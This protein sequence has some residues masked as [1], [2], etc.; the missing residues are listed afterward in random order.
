M[1]QGRVH[2][3]RG[4]PHA[5]VGSDRVALVAQFSAGPVQPRSLSEYL[6]RLDAAGYATVVISTCETTAPLEFPAGVPTDTMVIRRP[7][8][9][10]D[11]GSWATALGCIP[12]LREA[13]TVLLTN[14]SLLGPFGPIEHLLEWAAAPGPDIRGLTA[15]YQFAYHV[16]S[17]FLAYR[18]GILADRPWRD[19]FNSVRVEPGKDEVVLSYEIGVSRTAFS[20]C[21]SSEV[22]VTGPELGVPYGNPTVDGW[23]NLI[24]SGVPFLKRTIMTHPSTQAEAAEAAQYIRRRFGTD[25]NDW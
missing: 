7:N 4:D 12:E 24:E 25:V 6:Q 9:G 17:Y 14:D 23:K 3:E 8:L 21:Y 18:G 22:W 19:F 11:F 10:Y 15:S 1:S 2:I 13:G 20:E 16:Q 5:V